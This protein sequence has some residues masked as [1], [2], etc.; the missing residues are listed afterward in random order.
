MQDD[1]A[2]SAAGTSFAHQQRQQ[3]PGD[4]SAFGEHAG[5]A[6][7]AFL[8]TD[9]APPVRGPDTAPPPADPFD[10]PEPHPSFAVPRRRQAVREENAA[11]IE[12]PPAMA[13]EDFLKSRLILEFHT[14][15][16]QYGRQR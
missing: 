13:K 10:L 2:K 4:H 16:K 1:T 15:T 12:A 5:R 14:K 6:K 9:M 11:P 3:L 8:A 7:D